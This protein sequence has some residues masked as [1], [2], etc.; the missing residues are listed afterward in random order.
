MEVFSSEMLQ[1]ICALTEG[2]SA[3]S[4]PKG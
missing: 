1:H 3:E 4:T 2:I